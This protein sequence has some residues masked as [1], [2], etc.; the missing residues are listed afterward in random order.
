MG[1]TAI[2]IATVLVAACTALPSQTPAAQNLSD[3]VGFS[4]DLPSDWT[5]VEARKPAANTPSTPAPAALPRKGTGC[6]QLALT[7]MHGSPSSVVVVVAL[8]FNCYGQTMSAEDLNGFGSGAADG[9]KTDFD[10]INPVFG[11][12]SLGSHP[13]WIERARGNAKGRT[14]PQY[15]VEIA[16]ALLEKGAAC[17]ITMA[18]DKASLQTFEQSPVTLDDEA[19]RPLVPFTA[20]DKA[21]PHGPS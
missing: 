11:V 8:P 9:L 18:A 16:C 17:W 13:V 15:T 6:V 19:A 12:Y 20:F 2:A 3:E 7:A 1:K 4:Y 21:P 14:Q 5:V 10:L